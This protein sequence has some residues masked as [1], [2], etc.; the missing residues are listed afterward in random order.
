M[1]EEAKSESMRLL[2][3][4]VIGDRLND[5][6]VERFTTVKVAASEC[7]EVKEK[8]VTYYALGKPAID[9][10]AAAA[11]ITFDPDRTGVKGTPSRDYLLFEAVGSLKLPDGTVITKKGTVE[12]DFDAV[13][14]PPKR[15]DNETNER[16]EERSA[17]AARVLRRFRIP[18]SETKA[19]LRVVRALL[20]L[21]SKYT[22]AELKH[23]FEV[24]HYDYAPNMDKPEVRALVMA[25]ADTSHR[26]L[27]GASPIDPD[28]RKAL[29]AAPA[30][31][32]DVTDA[33]PA[34][35]P[36]EEVAEFEDVPQGQAPAEAEGSPEGPVPFDEG[37]KPLEGE[38]IDAGLEGV[39]A[40]PAD[41]VITD[42]R[43]T[44][45]GHALGEVEAKL[46]PGYVRAVLDRHMGSDELQAA[47]AEYAQVYLDQRP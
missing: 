29:S 19:M 43:S 36:V 1:A 22:A 42:S 15:Y 17:E 23:P 9:K 10:I 5:F 4:S 26:A 47:C 11:G 38:V 35:F 18:M 32:E 16:Y 27:Y 39:H 37:E 30:D 12:W 20:G 40:D 14:S 31:V 41:Y 7:F 2:P 13:W 21:K 44:F 24:P 8:G 28:E 33:S 25:Q 46:K 45:R 34:D 3:T 6:Y